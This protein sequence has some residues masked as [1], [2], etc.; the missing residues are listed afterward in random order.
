MKTLESLE[1][2]L[3]KQRADEGDLDAQ[4]KVG[5]CYKYGISTLQSYMKAFHYYKLAADQ[6]DAY[7][8]LEV[9]YLYE[10]IFKDLSQAFSYYKLAAHQN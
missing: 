2:I 10:D 9:A 5:D 6:G 8:Q 7:A 3:L 4:I 1:F